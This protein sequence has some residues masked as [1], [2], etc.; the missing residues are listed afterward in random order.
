VTVRARTIKDDPGFLLLEVSDTGCGISSGMTE[1]IFERLFQ[2]SDPASAG[3]QGL[4]LGLHICKELVTRHGGDIW[5]KSAPGQGS[6]FSVTLPV[7]SLPTLIAPAIRRERC[8][9]GPVTLVVTEIGSRAGWVSDEARAEQAHGVRELLQRC[10]HCDR[11][12]L[13]PKMGVAGRVELLFIVAITDGIGG[14]A[15]TKRIR[16][17]WDRSEQIQQKDL[18]LSASYRSLGAIKRDV[19]E[20]MEAF[21]E[22]VAGKMQELL[23]QEIS[24]RMVGNEQ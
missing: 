14:E 3:R 20:S 7:F 24:L 5:A 16:E 17:Q 12:I 22:R 11:D 18:T 4:G 23:D 21:L 15:I 13:L 2:A 9:E 6:V 19:G 1:Q 10:L 8:A